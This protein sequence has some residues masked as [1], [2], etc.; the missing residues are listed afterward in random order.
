MTDYIYEMLFKYGRDILSHKT[1]SIIGLIDEDGQLVESNEGLSIVRAQFT[2]VKEF[3]HMLEPESHADFQHGVSEALNTNLT[4]QT[5]LN[6]RTAKSKIPLSFN[7]WFVPTP[8]KKVILYGDFIPPLDIKSDPEY[9]RLTGELSSARYEIHDLRDRVSGLQKEITQAHEN[10]EKSNRI[11]PLTGLPNRVSILTYFEHQVKIARR[12]QSDLCIYV[13]NFDHFKHL[14]DAYGY[15]VGDLVLQECAEIILQRMRGSDFLGRYAGDEFIGILPETDLKSAEILAS[16]LC[17]QI[18]ETI[19]NAG[20]NAPV[21]MT[22]SIG[23]AQFQ[24]DIDNADALL[25]RKGSLLWRAD[26]A[27][28]H[29]KENGRNRVHFWPEPG[30]P[31]FN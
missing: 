31:L 16:R 2:E 29:A 26:N 4:M 14:N 10:L 15:H 12:Y 25:W 6:F 22:V 21:K 5:T 17:K 9:I 30:T 3:K 20:E 11:D 18:E 27:L 24:P 19:F 23:M 7:C 13:L 28:L 8:D 1:R